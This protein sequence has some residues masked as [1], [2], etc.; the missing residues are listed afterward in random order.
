M[1]VLAD[2][3]GPARPAAQFHAIAA[4]GSPQMADTGRHIIGPGAEGGHGA[5]SQTRLVGAIIARIDRQNWRQRQHLAKQQGA[6][7]G[8]PQAIFR[9]DQG[10]DGRG[11]QA[12]GPLGPA[13]KRWM[14]RS[15]EREQNIR[16]QVLRQGC[17]N[18]AAPFVQGVGA[19]G[20][21]LETLPKVRP[22]IADKHNSGRRPA[23]T[24]GGHAVFRQGVKA[25]PW[26]QTQRQQSGRNPLKIC[27][28]HKPSPPPAIHGIL[29]AM[30][31]ITSA[32]RIC[33]LIFAVGLSA[34]LGQCQ[35]VPRPFAAA[36]K[37]DFS[38]IQIGPRAGMV[39]LPVTGAV[40][41]DVGG[42]LAAATA[43][44]LRRR[45]VTASTNHGH[46]GSHRLS[47]SAALESNG[48]LRLTWRLRTP[49]DLETMTLTQEDT[50]APAAW[51]QGEGA[52]LARLAG[53]A[54][55]A[56]DLRLRRQERGEGRRIALAPVTMGPVD[57]VPGRGGGQ[58][59]EAMRT[60]LAKAG[61][62]L[63]RQPADDG[64][65]LLGSMRVAPDGGAGTGGGRRIEVVWQLIRPDGQEFGQVSQ[66]N[67]VPTAQLAGDWRDLAQ[68]IARAGAPGV[69]DLLR[70]DRGG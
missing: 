27:F 6:P 15:I 56:I 23:I 55:E 50:V 41:A 57:G 42:K 2:G 1:I 26:D 24:Q 12:F 28:A 45:E 8:V 30:N 40:A 46:R 66:A 61:V 13:L 59:A 31:M 64:F 16:A 47:G 60:A 68:A 36:H 33:C 67:K 22:G 19:G 48:R 20:V 39:V 54:A 29:Q 14:G 43:R 7:I 53:R 37:G 62:P 4:G 63:S 35:P 70:R 11:W 69:L 51:R 5:G 21:A 10:T 18:L 65:I 58:L 49:E 9:M 17:Q 32:R 25:P 44:A 52:L 38:A 3:T 34:L